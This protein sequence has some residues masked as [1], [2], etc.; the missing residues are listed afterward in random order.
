MPG[1]N[2]Y[3]M[4]PALM[5]G[6]TETTNTPTKTTPKTSGVSKQMNDLLMAKAGYYTPTKPVEE[7]KPVENQVPKHVMDVML[8]KMGARPTEEVQPKPEVKP[9]GYSEFEQMLAQTPDHL[10]PQLISQWQASQR[11]ANEPKA[12]PA[13]VSKSNPTPQVETPTTAPTT[14]AA[15][16]QHVQSVMMAKMGVRPSE[17]TT[18]V[19]QPATLGNKSASKLGDPYTNLPEVYKTKAFDEQAFRDSYLA[20]EHGA[21]ASKRD[22]RRTNKFFNSE[23]GKQAIANAKKE[24]DTNEHKLWSDSV[25][26]RRQALTD[27]HSRRVAA[28]KAEWDA[29]MAKY[30]AIGAEESKPETPKQPAQESVVKAQLTPRSNAEWQRI[31]KENGFADMGEVMAWQEANGLEADGKFG[32]NSS[33]FFKTNGLGKYQRTPKGFVELSRQDGSTFLQRTGSSTVPQASPQ[34]ATNTTTESEV[35]PKKKNS[36][37]ANATMAAAMADAPAVMTASGWRQ[38]EAGDYVQDREDDPGVARLRNNI[39]V[40]GAGTLAGTAAAAFAPAAAAATP[41]IEAPASTPLLTGPAAKYQLYDAAGKLLMAYKTGGTM[42]RIN[43][44]QQGGAAPQQ[45]MQSQ[46]VALV[47]AAMQG[48]QKATQTVNQIMEAAKAGDQQAM[49]IAQMIQEVAKQMQGQATAA[50]WGAKLGYIKSLKYAKGGKTCPACE[51]KVEM[52][53]CGGKK[54][55]KKYF[56]GI[57]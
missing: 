35:K 48:D 18:P 50:K 54:A 41:A 53:K 38:N 8:A 46:V 13:L 2:M 33:A 24:H 23:E 3:S 6:S 43:Y 20:K 25:S 42:N 34:T 49:Q 51:Q 45:D 28:A 15:Q 26:A 47:Q 27:E 52:K 32:D 4:D 55:K 21:Q 37:F 30:D 57:L 19:A 14:P 22:I 39:A 10:K 7:T 11:H 29:A 17:P 31:A 9:K 40:L 12:T 5:A 36:W 1:S 16:P 44:F 56:G